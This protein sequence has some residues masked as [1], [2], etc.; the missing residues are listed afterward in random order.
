MAVWTLLD[1]SIRSGIL[2]VNPATDDSRDLRLPS[3]GYPE[4][5]AGH[6]TTTEAGNINQEVRDIPVRVITKENF[7]G[8]FEGWIRTWTTDLSEF[9]ENSLFEDHTREQKIEWDGSQQT[10]NPE[11]IKKRTDI[12]TKEDIRG[13]KN[14][15]LDGHL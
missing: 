14:D 10:I 1:A 5:I 12:F 8:H 9:K 15:L 4:K 6:S 7:G 3:D 2:C 13:S 11:E